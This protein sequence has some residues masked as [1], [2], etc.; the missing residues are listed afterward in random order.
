VGVF[1]D[2]ALRVVCKRLAKDEEESFCGSRYD[3]KA[4]ISVFCVVF[5]DNGFGEEKGCNA[6]P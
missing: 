1:C 2:A 4:V 6:P 5:Q 3:V